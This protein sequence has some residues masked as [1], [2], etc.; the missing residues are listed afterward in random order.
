MKCYLHKDFTKEL[1]INLLGYVKH[2][3]YISYYLP[4]AF[5]K[6]YLNYPDTCDN[7]ESLLLF[8]NT[9]Q[10]NLEKE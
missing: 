5:G 2:N 7:C 1:N 4:H 8:F 9:L 6:Y 3:K 10:K